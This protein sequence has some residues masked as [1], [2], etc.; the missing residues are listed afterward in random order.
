MD[1][2]HPSIFEFFTTLYAFFLGFALVTLWSAFLNA[3]R[4]VAKEADTL[5]SAYRSSLDLPDSGDFR[6]ALRGYV[7]LVLEDEWDRMQVG[8]MSPAASRQF[9]QMWEQLRLSK[10]KNGSG[11]DLYLHVTTLLEEASSQRLSRGL[12]LSG[13]LYPP[14]WVIITFGFG[15][16]LFGL[17][18]L[19][20]RQTMVRLIF[21]FMVLFL[22]LSC[23]YFIYDIN[24]PFSGYVN[25]KSDA[26][27]LVQAK[28]QA[29]P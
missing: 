8:T 26:F 14:I 10:P 3:E 9:D 18:F 25:V 19:H 5:L 20:V 11:M 24:T 29:L 27:Q 28:M 21:N 16:I 23:I 22:L 12:F 2:F 4:N 7:T 6:Q 13:N 1:Q 15:T 17:Y